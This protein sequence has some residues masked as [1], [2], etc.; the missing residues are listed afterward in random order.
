M[1][2]GG[3]TPV[4]VVVLTRNEEDNIAACLAGTAR[5]GGPTLVVDSGSTDR[6]AALA[7]EAG[8]EVVDF[9]WDGRYP[10]KK[11]WSIDHAT[12]RFGPRWVL[13]LDADER[14]SEEAARFVNAVAADDVDD[15]P[16]AYRFPIEYR[17]AGGRNR[18][19]FRARKVAL[20]RPDRVRFSSRDDLDVPHGWEVE[21]HYQPDADG[22]VA[23]APVPLVHDDADH[24]HDWVA[25]HNRY[26]DWSAHLRFRADRGTTVRTEEH[27]AKRYFERL[28]FRG[29]LAFVHS[30]VV[31]RGFLDGSAGFDFAVARA[32]H[33]WLGAAKLRELRRRDRRS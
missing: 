33:Y 2:R 8:A 20:L 23:T 28:P 22:E 30:F 14:L 9:D 10:K 19:G 32:F 15:G 29:V 27:R 17:F 5:I 3:S 24:L 4:A 6:T 16:V 25:R 31:K 12:R 26:S 21:G 18:H 11:Q 13:L 1:E 7:R